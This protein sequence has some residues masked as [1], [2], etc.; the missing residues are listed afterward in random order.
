ILGLEIC[1]DTMVGDEM[2]RGIS[3]G[4]RKRVTT[5]EM[6]VGPAKVLFMDEISTGLDSSTT[7]Q[8]GPREQV[9]EFFESMGFKY[10]VRKGVA[11][12]LQECHAIYNIYNLHFVVFLQYN[13][14]NVLPELSE[15]HC[16]Y[17]QPS[18]EDAGVE[19]KL[20]S[21]DVREEVHVSY[22]NFYKDVLVFGRAFV[23]H[24]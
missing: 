24:G 6:L 4:Q 22:L 13:Q 21:S 9:V 7:F 10:P 17:P 23:I 20:S 11:D 1:A 15:V 3:G 19:S 14:L 5:G 12:F 18:K 16:L 8:I 2:V